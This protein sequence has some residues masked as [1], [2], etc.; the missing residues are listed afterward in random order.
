MGR[1]NELSLNLS[2]E[3]K[4]VSLLCCPR[5]LKAERNAFLIPLLNAVDN[6]SATT[7]TVRETG[8]MNYSVVIL[9][10]FTLNW[11]SDHVYRRFHS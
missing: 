7:K 6:K 10:I 3:F 2:F 1:R 11:K 9:L 8:K 4:I 5:V